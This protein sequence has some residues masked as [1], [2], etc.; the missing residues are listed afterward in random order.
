MRKVL[1]GNVAFG[2][3]IIEGIVKIIK[4]PS[5][6]IEENEILVTEITSP[7]FFSQMIKCKGMITDLGGVLCH[8]A[9][10]ARELE[11]P[12]IVGTEKATELLKDG[13]KILINLNDG[14]I[15]ASN[16]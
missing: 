2:D 3:G 9:I 10:L 8:T 1:D 5:E 4:E 15:Y 13:E 6:T 7:K 16:E 11:K 14:K 12:C